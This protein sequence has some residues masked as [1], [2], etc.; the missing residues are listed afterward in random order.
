MQELGASGDQEGS[1]RS[2]E[3]WSSAD[4]GDHPQLPDVRQVPAPGGI[5]G[6][7]GAQTAPIPTNQSFVFMLIM[8]FCV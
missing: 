6:Q 5:S 4:G 1:V 8:V 2:G 3:A 7:R